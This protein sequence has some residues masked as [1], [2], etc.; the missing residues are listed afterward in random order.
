[1]EWVEGEEGGREKMQRGHGTKGH[2]GEKKGSENGEHAMR[3]A[4]T[5]AGPRPKK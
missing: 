1:M 2:T 4:R 5:S 3:R